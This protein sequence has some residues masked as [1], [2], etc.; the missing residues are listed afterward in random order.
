MWEGKPMEDMTM[1]FNKLDLKTW[2]RSQMFYYFSKM[3]PTR[4]SITVDVDVTDLMDNLKRK[5]K[6]INRFIQ[7]PF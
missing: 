6:D 3:A 7:E 4:Y 2:E 1:G 5:V